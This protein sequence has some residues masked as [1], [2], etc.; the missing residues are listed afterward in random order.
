MQV[1]E[2]FESSQKLPKALPGYS[3]GRL[4]GRSTEEK[5]GE[6][7]EEGKENEQRQEKVEKIEE[8]I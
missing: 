7:G 5:G 8:E 3:G 1:I 4:P 2:D 6:K